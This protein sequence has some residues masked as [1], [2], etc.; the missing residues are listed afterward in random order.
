MVFMRYNSPLHGA[1]NK[2]YKDGSPYVMVMVETYVDNGTDGWGGAVETAIGQRGAQDVGFGFQAGGNTNLTQAGGGSASSMLHS[3]GHNDDWPMSDVCHSTSTTDG[4]AY[5][6]AH[7]DGNG[8]SNSEGNLVSHM[9]R[10]REMLTVQGDWTTGAGEGATVLYGTST[11]PYFGTYAST[12]NFDSWAVDEGDTSDTGSNQFNMTDW[13]TELGYTIIIPY[14]EDMYENSTGKCLFNEGRV[15]AYRIF[16]PQ[17]GIIIKHHGRG[18]DTTAEQWKGHAMAQHTG[19]EGVADRTDEKLAPT[20]FW[21]PDV[22]YTFGASFV[23]RDENES[24]IMDS[25]YSNITLDKYEQFRPGISLRG[26]YPGWVDK[27]RIYIKV[28][29]GS[30]DAWS[31]FMESDF[32]SCYFYKESDMKTNQTLYTIPNEIR[33]QGEKLYNKCGYLDEGTIHSGFDTA[34]NT[35]Q[36]NSELAFTLDGHKISRMNAITYRLLNGF[37]P[38]TTDSERIVGWETSALVNGIL[39]VGAI[40]LASGTYYSDKLI[41]SPKFKKPRYDNL[42]FS[43]AIDLDTQD[44][45]EIIQLVDYGNYL[46]VFKKNKV[47]VVSFTNLQQV[48]VVATFDN[49]GIY[50][51]EAATKTESGVIWCNENGMYSYGKDGLK[52]ITKGKISDRWWRD[53]AECNLDNNLYK[54][55]VYPHFTTFY[56]STT[57]CVH[58]VNGGGVLNAGGKYMITYNTQ[59]NSFTFV[60]S[61]FHH[62]AYWGG[63][64][65]I[66]L[67]ANGPATAGHAGRRDGYLMTNINTL[68]R[69]Q[70]R[71]FFGYPGDMMQY[72]DKDFFYIGKPIKSKFRGNEDMKVLTDMP[73]L[74]FHYPNMVS[75]GGHETSSSGVLNVAQKT[76]SD[77]YTAADTILYTDLRSDY[78]SNLCIGDFIVIRDKDAI[79]DPMADMKTNGVEEI[80][81]VLNMENIATTQ[82]AS[83]VDK[84]TVR[85]GAL[86]TTATAFTRTDDYR[87]IRLQSDL[88]TGVF[89]NYNTSNYRKIGHANVEWETPDMHMT[90]ADVA[91]D[92]GSNLRSEATR[93]RFYKLIVTYKNGNIK[94]TD[95]TTDS[96]MRCYF[97]V[98]GKAFVYDADHEMVTA[99]AEPTIGASAFKVAAEDW[100]TQELVPK[101]KVLCKNNY[102]I[103]FRFVSLEQSHYKTADSF[104]VSRKLYM[105]QIGDGDEGDIVRCGNWCDEAVSNSPILTHS[106]SELL[107]SAGSPLSTWNTGVASSTAALYGPYSIDYP[108]ERVNNYTLIMFNDSSGSKNYISQKLHDN[109]PSA[110]S[111]EANIK[112]IRG[113]TYRIEVHFIRDEN[114]QIVGDNT[115]GND[116]YPDVGSTTTNTRLHPQAS[117]SSQSNYDKVRGKSIPLEV[118]ITETSSTS[119]VTGD[120]TSR[121]ILT[122]TGTHVMYYTAPKGVTYDELWLH[123]INHKSGS[124]YTYA[125]TVC[126]KI[127]IRKVQN[128][129]AGEFEI[130]DMNLIF[131]EKTIK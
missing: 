10:I 131:R 50:T 15:Y 78:T 108:D 4:T 47:I 24:E 18:A 127:S 68:R 5:D 62:Q 82:G 38:A 56:D 23:D 66:E 57:K 100:Y 92:T 1:V 19:I 109:T 93:K 22:T 103:R 91:A 25:G 72:W 117:A 81:Q 83:A 58:A 20:V 85:R 122:E 8:S 80:M 37:K 52:N 6:I 31:L 112:M 84:V 34:N 53:L 39:V 3:G 67:S 65:K 88:R 118:Q 70:S 90:A 48:G 60:R 49:N 129:P 77:D 30:D 116:I 40:R 55:R 79:H 96:R 121:W 17:G 54:T 73:Y 111:G 113:C 102:S 46:L 110:T 128:L 124:S 64:S 36:F 89:F 43:S 105:E 71:V 98:D 59:L 32:R 75:T 35:S 76:G 33:H 45:D 104:G 51:K 26:P 125:Y 42:H 101:N 29:G 9:V 97:A 126:T 115:Y 114:N 99:K 119:T 41:W 14:L 12:G 94:E 11:L 7:V 21:K 106:G 28:S 16:P 44:G 74:A 120:D 13:S 130:N 63:Q 95:G 86:K 87:I 61:A 2:A 107:D 69:L 123:L 27:I